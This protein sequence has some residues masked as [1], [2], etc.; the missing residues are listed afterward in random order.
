[1][2]DA[3]GLT[4]HYGDHIA[5]AGVDLS[6]GA[7]EFVSVVG[8]NGAGKTSLVHV[9]TGLLRPS[10]GAVRFEGR[11]IVGMG[12]VRLARLGLVRSFQLVAVFPELS[13]LDGLRV[14][15]AARL[16]RTRRLF[17]SL[18]RDREVEAEARH[19]AALFGLDGRADVPAARLGQGDKKLLD[20]ASAFAARPRLILLDEPTS[21]VSTAD[22]RAVM[23]TV[24]AAAGAM[25]VQTIV[26]VEHDMDLVFA[27]SDRVI[28]LHQGRVLADGPP[29]VIREDEQVVATVL[30]KREAP[31]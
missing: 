29:E 12:P 11:D 13:V 6:I 21:G 2:L 9:L 18:A 3:R 20:V 30:G 27:Y 28:A 19:I 22:K 7:G 24:V 16:G 31:C 26:A 1:M 14:A 17:G 5:L 10:G 8:P 15:V 23:D 25:G 4:L